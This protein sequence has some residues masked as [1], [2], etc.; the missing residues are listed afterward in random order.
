M[1]IAMNRCIASYRGP[2]ACNALAILLGA[3][4][5][6]A[7]GTRGPAVSTGNH[8]YS[9]SGTSPARAA[10]QN[11]YLYPAKTASPPSPTIRLSNIP[12]F[13][14]PNL[15]QTTKPVQFLS[16]TRGGTFFLAPNEL[17]LSLSGNQAVNQSISQLVNGPTNRA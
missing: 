1:M 4:V 3:Q 6:A 9:P 8:H 11:P 17:V 16:H 7:A 14:E 10:I 5:W 2:L 15:G 13:F 12:L